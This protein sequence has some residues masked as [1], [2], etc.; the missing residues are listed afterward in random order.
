MADWDITQLDSLEHDTIQGRFNSLVQIDDTHFI[1]AYTGT[2]GD[3]FIKTFSVNLTTGVFPIT[4]TILS[5][6]LFDISIAPFR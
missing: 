1:L 4:C 3:G 2:D 5:T 6:G